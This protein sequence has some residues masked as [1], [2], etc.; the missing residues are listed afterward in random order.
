M[1]R[2]QLGCIVDMQATNVRK[3]Q[4]ITQITSRLTKMERDLTSAQTRFQE[5]KKLLT[6]REEELLKAKAEVHC[7]P[8][9][10]AICYLCHLMAESCLYTYCMH[11]FQCC[12][13]RGVQPHV[14]R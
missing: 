9:A 2:Q 11:A 10:C 13:R 5:E 6:S 7:D 14:F 3:D 4:T 1:I 8:A 12:I